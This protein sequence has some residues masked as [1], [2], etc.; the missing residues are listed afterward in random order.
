[1]SYVDVKN[2]R[3][4]FDVSKPWLNR[5]LEGG[6]PEGR[7]LGGA[8]L[9]GEVGKGREVVAGKRGRERELPAGQLHAVAAVAGEADDDAFRRNVGAGFFGGDQMGGCRHRTS[10]PARGVFDPS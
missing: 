5:M 1:M 2:L 4:V 6:D 10:N 7:P 8:D 9:G 3:R